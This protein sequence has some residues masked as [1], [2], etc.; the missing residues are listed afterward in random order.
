MASSSIEPFRVDLGNRVVTGLTAGQGG[1][2]LVLLHGIGSAARSFAAS[3]AILAENRRVIAWN[4]PGYGGSTPLG[5]DE[6]TAG[7]YA[8]VLERLLDA[9]GIAHVHLLGHSLGAIVA[10]RFAA[11]HP[12]R[13]ASLTLASVALGHARLDPERRAALL[14]AR[15]DDLATL[16]PAGLAEKRGP[17]LCGPTASPEAIRAVVETMAAVEPEGYGDA[18]R[19]LSRTDTL[20]DVARLPSDLP[21][22]VA[23]GGA[24]VITPPAANLEVVAAFPGARRAVVATAGHAFYVEEPSQFAQLVSR[25]LQDPP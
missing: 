16:G 21:L 20:A 2:P 25:H 24:D 17:R 7:A 10:A 19:M 13:L 23:W 18:A 22:L 1:V 6:P 14:A 4:A 8:A 15:L 3:L 5:V 12:D 11:D 9:L